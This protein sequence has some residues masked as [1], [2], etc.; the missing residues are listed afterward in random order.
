[1]TACRHLLVE[2]F[3]CGLVAAGMLTILLTSYS[4]DILLPS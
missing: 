2:P 4:H 3:A 1:M